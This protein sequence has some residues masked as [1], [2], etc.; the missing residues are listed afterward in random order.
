MAFLATMN[1][2]DVPALRWDPRSFINFSSMPTSLE[3]KNLFI[4]EELESLVVAC[5]LMTDIHAV[6]VPEARL[7][8]ALEKMKE[9]EVDVLPVFSTDKDPRLVGMIERGRIGQALGR[10]I[11]RRNREE[12]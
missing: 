5:D 2:A 10:E 11:I 4:K 3:I 6:T 12:A 9:M 8:E 7:M 1:S